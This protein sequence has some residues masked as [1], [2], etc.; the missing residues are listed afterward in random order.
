MFLLSAL[1]SFSTVA[2]QTLV[3]VNTTLGPI[4]GY[5]QTSD[6]G[7]HVNTFRGVPFA[8]STGGANRWY[9]S[10]ILV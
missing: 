1:L 6:E 9:G 7:V 10:Q 4:F 3:N 2:S 5:V 8:A